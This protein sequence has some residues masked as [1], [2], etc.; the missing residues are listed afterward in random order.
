MEID[1]KIIEE[2]KDKTGASYN[3]AK[4]ALEK[5]KGNVEEAI[6]SL[7]KTLSEKA[8][9]MD[10]KSWKENPIY[11]KMKEIID[12]GNISRIIIKKDDKRIIEIPLTLSVVG[13][14]VVP[15]VTI[16]G[17]VS[18]IGTQCK[19]EFIDDNGKVTNVSNKVDGAY[20]KAKD[21]AVKGKD[22]AQEL[23]NVGVDKVNEYGI[24][25]KIE[26]IV[27][28]VEEKVDE[29]SKKI[30]FD[31]IEEKFEDVKDGVKEKVEEAKDKITK[32]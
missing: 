3:E 19:I 17:I 5:T 7:A 14:V 8:E 27:G 2:V 6:K 25:E 30:N 9:N 24:P 11:I 16:V 18:A 13:A 22:K 10:D 21:F 31:D 28:K 1:L 20:E 23:Y 12:K 15:W 4:D 26:G 29:I 32:K